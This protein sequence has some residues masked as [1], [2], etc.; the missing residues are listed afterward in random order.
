LKCKA[1]GATKKKGKENSFFRIIKSVFFHF[2]SF[3]PLLLHQCITFSFFVQI[4]RFKLLWN[5][6]FKLYKSS[7]N[8]KGNIVILKDFLRGLEIGYELLNREFFAKTT[9]LVRGAHN[10]LT[11]SSFFSIF[12]AIDAPTIGLHLLFGHYKQ[13]GPPAK[14]VNKT[15][16]KW[17]FMSY[18]TL[19]GSIWGFTLC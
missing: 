14:T 4:E 3:W 2:S 19:C 13:W 9:S 17:L 5:C 12:S 6:Y 1:K 18:P 7:C 16:R 10:F 15:Y 11:S 8:S